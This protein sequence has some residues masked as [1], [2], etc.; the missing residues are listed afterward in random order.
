METL[1]MVAIVVIAL[2]V[3]AQAGVLIAMYL[4]SRRLSTKAEALMDDTRRLMAPMESI[5]GNLRTVADDLAEAG[6]IAHMQALEVQDLVTEATD[7]IRHDIEDVRYRVVSTVE[8][9]RGIVMRPLRESSAI[10][11]GIAAGVRT[12]FGR[13]RKPANTIDEERPAA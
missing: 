3:I 10:A 5:M 6:K 1:L 9:A 8:T 2:A 13:G 7:N 4:M 11:A 12:F